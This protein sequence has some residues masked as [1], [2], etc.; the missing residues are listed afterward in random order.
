MHYHNGLLCAGG[1]GGR[2]SVF[3]IPES[4]QA[5]ELVHS[6]KAAAGWIGET[7]FVSGGT[8]ERRLLMTSSNSGEMSI[9]DLSKKVPPH[10]LKPHP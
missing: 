6:F 7:R 3:G 5:P 9:W 8:A 4:S 1:H 10:P 2:V